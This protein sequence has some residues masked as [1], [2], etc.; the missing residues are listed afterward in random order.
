MSAERTV[1]TAADVL[2]L[3]TQHAET[4]P[5]A[6]Q[7]AFYD[8]ILALVYARMQREGRRRRSGGCAD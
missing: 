5:A 7:V 1:L 3:V 6:E 8:A 2:A 4:L